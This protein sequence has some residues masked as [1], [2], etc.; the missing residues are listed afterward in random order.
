MKNELCCVPS[1][2]NLSLGRNFT[3]VLLAECC[4]HH[5]GLGLIFKRIAWGVVCWLSELRLLY[6][7]CCG[8][9]AALWHRFDLWSRNSH[10]LPVWPKQNKTQR[11]PEI[12]VESL[13]KQNKTNKKIV[14][15]PSNRRGEY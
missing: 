12:N 2:A 10:I 11:E 6:S 1:L 8:S 4:C 3:G 13:I 7:L 5:I 15:C 9:V 14:A